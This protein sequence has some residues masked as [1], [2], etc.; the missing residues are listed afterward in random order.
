MKT[1]M[2]S[3]CGSNYRIWFE[4][5]LDISI[6]RVHLTCKYILIPC[7]YI[8][9]FIMVTWEYTSYNDSIHAVWIID[10][11]PN[12][13]NKTDC[14]MQKLIWQYLWTVRYTIRSYCWEKSQW[15]AVKICWRSKMAPPQKWDPPEI[16]K[17]LLP[18]HFS[19]QLKILK[20]LK[21]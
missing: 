21:F 4:R 2:A 20:I 5:W 19:A 3:V 11:D 15:A 14:L 1:F 13:L 18:F 12:S 16:S 17:H 7:A 9:P 6:R 10:F 8:L